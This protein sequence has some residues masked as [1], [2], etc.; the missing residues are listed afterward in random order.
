MLVLFR[1]VRNIGW[2]VLRGKTVI[3]VLS[4]FSLKSFWNR[5]LVGSLICRLIFLG[6]IEVIVINIYV[7]L[8]L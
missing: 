5:C 4:M 6:D 3:L 2:V 7:E 8:E 1:E